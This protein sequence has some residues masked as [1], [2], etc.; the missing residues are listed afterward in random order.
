[1][2]IQE[3]F[4]EDEVRRSLLYCFED[5]HYFDDLAARNSR[6]HRRNLVRRVPRP[7][8]QRLLLH[9]LQ[10]EQ[11][12]CLRRILPH[13][14]LSRKALQTKAARLG[15]HASFASA[16]HN[17][18]L[19][20]FL[21]QHTPPHRK[22]RVQ[23]APWRL[24]LLMFPTRRLTCTRTASPHLLILILEVFWFIQFFHNNFSFNLY[25]SINTV[26]GIQI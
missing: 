11:M 22:K 18:V 1:M 2:E 10:L 5:L 7:V 15:T 3:P 20:R 14:L 26:I 9:Q 21:P 13:P 19:S 4:E 16:T 12:W 6:L 17:R 23:S 8:L 24:V 25:L